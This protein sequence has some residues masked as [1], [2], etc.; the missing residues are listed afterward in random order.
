MWTYAAGFDTSNPVAIGSDGTVYVSM[1]AASGGGV[2]ALN[3]ATGEVVWKAALPNKSVP[4]GPVY[5]SNT[6][7]VTAYDSTP[8]VYGWLGVSGL[9]QMD[10][11][12]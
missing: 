6:L 12:G 3:G 10:V 7:F 9:L 2:V 11:S 4:S 8:N 5:F 1:Q